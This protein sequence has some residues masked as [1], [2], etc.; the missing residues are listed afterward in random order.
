M[1]PPPPLVLDVRPL[2]AAG[3]PPL[4]AIL[5]AVHR[6]QSNQALRLIAPFEPVPL[7]ELLGNRGFTHTAAVKDDD[8]WEILFEPEPG[9]AATD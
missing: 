6:L 3:N 7:Y 2:C 9:Q 1:N 8:S 4:G 5:D